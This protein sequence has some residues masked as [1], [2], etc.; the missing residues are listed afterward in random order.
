MFLVSKKYSLQLQNH[1]GQPRLCNYDAESVSNE[2]ELPQNC[3]KTG[4]LIEKSFNYVLN[5][6]R[7][8]PVPDSIGTTPQSSTLNTLAQKTTSYPTE[9]GKLNLMQVKQ[10]NRS[11]YASSPHNPPLESSFNFFLSI[12]ILNHS[13]EVLLIPILGFLDSFALPTFKLS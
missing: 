4:Y 6:V 7:C 9:I 1:E 3:S 5:A 8:P 13:S 2:N 10:Q 11:K 12:L